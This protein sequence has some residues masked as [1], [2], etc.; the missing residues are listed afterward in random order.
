MGSNVATFS[1]TINAV[2]DKPSASDSSETINEDAPDLAIDLGALVSDLET[3]DANLTYTIVSGPSKGV[4][5]GSGQNKSYN[6]N[7]DENG[8]DSFTYTVT[9]RGDPD[10][11][12]APGP[13]CDAPLSSDT[14]TVT[15][16]INPVNDAPSAAATPTSIVMDEDGAAESV[17]LSGGDVETAAANLEFTITAVPANGTLKKGATTLATGDTFTGSPTSVNYTPDA[18]YNG[19]DE[20]KFKVTDR[21]DPDNCGVPSA[22][23]DA[24]ASSAVVTVPITVNPVNDA[25]SA[26]AQSVTTNEDTAKVVTLAGADVDGDSLGFKVTSLAANGKLYAGSG[27]G[28][29]LIVAGDL[30]YPLA[31]NQVT[32][33]PNLNYNGPDSFNF[34]AHDGTVD[35]AAATVSITV[36]PVNDK[37]TVSADNATV[38]VNEGQTASNTGTYGDVDGD[39][40]TLS[41]SV[42]NVVKNSDGTWSWSFLTGDGPDQSQTVTITAND[43]AGGTETTS[44]ALTVVNVAPTASNASFVFDPIL[45]TATAGFDFSDV[46]LLDTHGPNLSF[47]TWSDVGNRFASVTE[48][49]AAPNATGH[50]SDTRTLNLRVATT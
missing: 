12:G 23:C 1:L 20:F 46:G 4:L 33:D 18:N 19:S 32:Y 29:H 39:T 40:V 41:A 17:S 31:G 2:N 7:A 42:G 14:K 13:A 25:P 28:G 38:S 16:T 45:G 26:T 6:V 48:E 15:I 11:C 30:P 37:P 9:D 27:T 21:G 43:G 49:N 34:K 8:T 5:S 10:N 24:K 22:T 47:F 50:A 35:S 44:F 36:T 3:S